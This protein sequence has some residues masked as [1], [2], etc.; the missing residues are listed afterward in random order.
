MHFKY[1]DQLCRLRLEMESTFQ[2]SDP[3]DVCGETEEWRCCDRHLVSMSPT[4]LVRV[5][6]ITG[7]RE[8]HGYQGRVAIRLYMQVFPSH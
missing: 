4:V 3:E 8:S 7:P 6:T 5:F 2:T 1:K